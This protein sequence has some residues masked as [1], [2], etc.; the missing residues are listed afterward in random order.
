MSPLRVLAR[1]ATQ[2]CIV[3]GSVNK[4][5]YAN[6]STQTVKQVD[7]GFPGHAFIRHPKY[8]SRYLTTQKWG[9]NAAVVDFE[10]ETVMKIDAGKENWF[11]GHGHYIEEKDAFYLARVSLETGKG[12][13]AAYDPET[14]KP[15]EAFQVTPGGL[16]DCHRMADKTLAIASSGVRAE[17]YS[18]PNKGMRIAK[19][20]IV[21][22]DIAGKGNV[23]RE[24]T[25]DDPWQMIGHFQVT[26]TGKIIALTCP[27]KQLDNYNM[28]TADHNNSGYVYFSSD[29]KQSLKVMDWGHDLQTQIKGVILSIAL[30]DDHTRAAVTN[31]LVGNI[32]LL[33]VVNEKVLKSINAPFKGV[34]WDDSLKGYLGTDRQLVWISPDFDKMTRLPIESAAG[35]QNPHSIIETV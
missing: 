11:Y 18:D 28:R 5:V 14:Y 25:I 15:G 29:G 26:K 4:A 19:S 6:L 2:E 23:V 22:V 12:Y 21:F 3:V 33:D 24:L 1:S 31:P 32:V 13:Y 30:N 35:F 9:A 17:K 34:V 27:Q 16:H 7:L 8:P 20:S 10:T